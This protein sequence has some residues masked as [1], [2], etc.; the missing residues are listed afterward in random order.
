[1]AISDDD[2]HAAAL[3]ALALHIRTVHFLLI[4]TCF[5]LAALAIASEPQ[6]QFMRAQNDLES[7]M[8]AN[9]RWSR[10]TPETLPNQIDILAPQ[11]IDVFPSDDISP[12]VRHTR[13][14]CVS[15]E[16]VD[17]YLNFL[18]PLLE[19][20]SSRGSSDDFGVITAEET[21]LIDVPAGVSYTYGSP[22]DLATWFNFWDSI[23]DPLLALKVT[24]RS[25]TWINSDHLTNLVRNRLSRI[26]FAGSLDSPP[27]GEI[28][29]IPILDSTTGMPA[30]LAKHEPN[31]RC[32]GIYSGSFNLVQLKSEAQ[33][34]WRAIFALPVGQRSPVNDREMVLEGVALFDATLE[35]SEVPAGWQDQVAKAGM[36]SWKPGNSSD[37]F[38]DLYELTKGVDSMT[39]EQAARLLRN[40]E[41]QAEAAQGRISI[42]SVDLPGQLAST[43]GIAV[44]AAIQLYLCLHVLR[45][46]DRQRKFKKP[47][48]AWI[49]L[50]PD[51]ASRVTTTLTLCILPLAS[52]GILATAAAQDGAL[53]SWGGQAALW[54]VIVASLVLGGITAIAGS[55]LNW[56]ARLEASNNREAQL[57]R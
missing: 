21:F 19:G 31:L 4:A 26:T 11:F 39:I 50:Y 8:R 55:K 36:A 37:T 6:R 1:M 9:E 18:T 33:D 15:I 27:P 5:T 35:K 12:N 42:A 34:R 57:G 20:K 43:W 25:L 44:V 38:P 16:P 30:D 22:A 3:D 40:L 54:I 49:G 52:V 13:K 28:D 23:R 14:D 32:Q 48:A 24:P 17:T 7:I 2:R 53:E 10:L 56:E 51:I 41:R 47:L 29:L 46:R 45:F